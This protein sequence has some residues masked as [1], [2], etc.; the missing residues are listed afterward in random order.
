[1]FVVQQYLA[2]VVA[3]CTVKGAFI[4]GPVLNHENHEYFAPRKLL[5]MQG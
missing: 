1:M 4:R 5:G 3:A 2:F